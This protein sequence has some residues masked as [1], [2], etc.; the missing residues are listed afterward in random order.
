MALECAGFLT[1][2]GFDTTVM[3]RSA[4]LGRFDK[5]KIYLLQSSDSFSTLP[6]GENHFGF[7]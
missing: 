1:S 5:V 3:V 4:P 7:T 2:L 6:V